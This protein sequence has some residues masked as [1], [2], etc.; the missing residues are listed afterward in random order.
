MYTIQKNTKKLY[1]DESGQN[2]ENKIK[3]KRGGIPYHFS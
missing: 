2:K 3:F 1:L